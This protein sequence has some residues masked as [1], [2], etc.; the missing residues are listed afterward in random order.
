MA[1]KQRSSALG[2]PPGA[3]CGAKILDSIMMHALFVVGSFEQQ[4][5]HQVS[6]LPTGTRLRPGR[7][8]KAV[9][10]APTDL[11]YRICQQPHWDSDLTSDHH[12]HPRRHEHITDD[13]SNTTL[14]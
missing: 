11:D 14:R 2:R 7:S 3:G 6:K 5:Q 4:L 12:H 10:R 9:S 1:A 8:S 13:L